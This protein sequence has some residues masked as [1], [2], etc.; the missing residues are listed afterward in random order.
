MGVMRTTLIIIAILN[1]EGSSHT[2][3]KNKV[4][5]IILYFF[6]CEGVTIR[7]PFFF[8]Q[9]EIFIFVIFF[10]TNESQNTMVKPK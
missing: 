10:Q 1:Y 7:Y 3:E 8:R 5:D 2:F 9:K 6:K 4:Y